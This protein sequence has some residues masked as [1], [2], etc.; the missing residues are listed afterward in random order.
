MKT[1]FRSMSCK[2]GYC[3]CNRS[4]PLIHSKDLLF[5]M[6]TKNMSYLKQT[7]T[8]LIFSGKFSHSVGNSAW[9]LNP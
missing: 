8:M 1:S 2:I 3:K 9:L 7:G 4:L 5:Y 6:E